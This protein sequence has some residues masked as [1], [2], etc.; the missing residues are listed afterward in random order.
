MGQ[1]AVARPSVIRGGTSY[2]MIGYVA[3]DLSRA[4][5][6]LARFV[7]P[8]AA[9]FVLGYW[10]GGS[11]DPWYAQVEGGDPDADLS[12]ASTAARALRLARD[13]AVRR[14][15]GETTLAGEDNL[16]GVEVEDPAEALRRLTEL[17]DR[18]SFGEFEL[19]YQSGAET[20]EESAWSVVF[21]SDELHDGRVSAT[22]AT[23]VEALHKARADAE[24]QVV[25]L[26][27]VP[28]AGAAVA[29]A[30]HVGAA[31]GRIAWR[32]ARRK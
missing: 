26:N 27:E 30:G 31:L 9:G 4:L 12:T 21:E 29:F 14:S 15:A 5:T 24:F 13:D 6:E 3:D 8:R 19:R 2:D 10:G 23:A 32:A 11:P 1:R 18:L 17:A 28:S 25:A 22:R 7:E 20:H 16:A